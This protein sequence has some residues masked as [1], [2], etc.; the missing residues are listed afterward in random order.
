M[1]KKEEK[2]EV[3]PRITKSSSGCLHGVNKCDDN[4]IFFNHDHIP[5]D[6]TR[7]ILTRLPAKSIVRFRC[8]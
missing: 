3:I 6:L 4:G 8:V 1:E 2:I 7:E 5:T